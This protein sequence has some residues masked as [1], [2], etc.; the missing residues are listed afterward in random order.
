MFNRNID[1][2]QTGIILKS[3]LM[4]IL[5]AVE[6]GRELNNVKSFWKQL[7]CKYFPVIVIETKTK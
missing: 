5:G 7:K 2:K 1:N 3:F 4:V 6:Q